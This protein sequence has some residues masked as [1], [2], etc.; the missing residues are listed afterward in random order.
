MIGQPLTETPLTET[1]TLFFS[2]IEGSTRLLQ[3]LGEGYAAKLAQ[4]R[5]ILRQAIAAHGGTEVDIHG[6]AFFAVFAEA[7]A[8]LVAAVQV[9]QSLANLPHSQP[10]RLQARIG[11]HSGQLNR[12]AEGYVGLDVHRA[13]RIMAAGH[14]GQILLSQTAHDRLATPLPDGVQLR[15]LGPHRLKDLPAP[16]NLYQVQ[17]PGL[18]HSFPP[19]RSINNRPHKLPAPL[20]AL[21]GREEE[22]QRVV[23]HLRRE[24]LRC[25]TMT[26][27]GGSGK[28]RLALNIGEELLADFEDGVFFV[29]LAALREPELLPAAIAQALDVKE[30]PGQT[31]LQG[32]EEYLRPKRLLLLL[33]NFEQIIEAA[34]VV[35]QLLIACPRLKVLITSRE[36]LRLSG[37]WE[38]PVPPLALPPVATSA[39]KPTAL[40]E[41]I[42]ASPAVQLFVERAQSAQWDFSLQHENAS[43]VADICRRLDGLPL[44]V[45]LAAAQVKQLPLEVLLSRLESRLQ[46]LT[47]G[48]RDVAQRQQT[49]YDTIGWSHDLLQEAEKILF[50]RLAVFSGGFDVASATLCLPHEAS[51]KVLSSRLQAL[52][53][54]N[55]LYQSHSD[56][57]DARFDMLETIHEFA[58]Q[59]LQQSEDG[60]WLYQAH[61]TFFLQL[62]ESNAEQLVGPQRVSSQ[63]ILAQNE[64]N[65]RVALQWSLDNEPLHALRLSGALWRFWEIGGRVAEGRGWL[66]AALKATASM[67]AETAIWRI[68]ALLGLGKLC[69]EQGDFV[70]ALPWLEQALALSEAQDDD[71]GRAWALL[72]LGMVLAYQAQFE[73]AQQV[74]TQSLQLF[75]SLNDQHGAA[76]ALLHLGILAVIPCDFAAATVHYQGCL[77]LARATGDLEL[78]A[79][80]LFYLGDAATSQEHYEV[81]AP[82]FEESAALSQTQAQAGMW[83]PYALWG[84]AIIAFE[85]GQPH[86]ARNLL[87]EAGHIVREEGRKWTQLFTI[88][89]YSHLLAT[90]GRSEDAAQLAGA[91]EAARQKIGFPL[92]A[93]YHARYSRHTN[94]MRAQL[95]DTAFEEMRL[96]GHNMSLEQALEFALQD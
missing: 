82:L 70:A 63:Q 42:A 43:Q 33:D 1:A 30:A 95:G 52:C 37:E 90:E 34:A 76:K 59:Q 60:A 79:Q 47:N 11:L 66:E 51:A 94:A 32:I 31:P 21:L 6:D 69:Y 49:L 29:G 72:H 36:S 92:P 7:T 35:T 24:D 84:Q 9:Q 71:R 2:D 15:P 62:A 4:Y 83:Y 73:R 50:R 45:E 10:E 67:G 12:I 89:A 91:A 48:P 54:K 75:Q 55:L 61:A 87:Q 23:A 13:A 14:G 20:T 8:A 93:A 80:A 78:V 18:A 26:G 77:D 3:R 64:A 17:A 16:E 74:L 65:F 86:R 41:T 44:A 53:A 56:D 25:L 40:M 19:L 39:Q 68:R 81:A 5:D 46:L 58:R 22:T 38:I 28:T 96:Q 85:Q 57:G 27:A 88:E